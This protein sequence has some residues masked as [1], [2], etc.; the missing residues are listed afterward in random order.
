MRLV[1]LLAEDTDGAAGFVV[2]TMPPGLLVPPHYHDREDEIGYTLS[3]EVTWILDGEEVVAPAGTTVWRPRGSRH[4]A[5]ASSA[6]AA[7]MLE[8][9]IPGGWEGALLELDRQIAAGALDLV[10]FVRDAA[11][12]GVHFDLAGGREIARERGLRVIGEPR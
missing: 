5:W 8:V 10:Q 1:K 12:R 4:A 7:R 2:S 9:M 11:E 3:G 6:D